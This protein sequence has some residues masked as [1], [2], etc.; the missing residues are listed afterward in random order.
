MKIAMFSNDTFQELQLL[1]QEKQH[2]VLMTHEKLDGD[3]CGALWA[4]FYAL[5]KYHFSLEIYYPGDI[6]LHFQHIIK[7]FSLPV[8]KDICNISHPSMVIVCDANNESVIGPWFQLLKNT[9]PWFTLVVFDHHA[10]S[11]HGPFGDIIFCDVSFSSTCELVYFFL[12]QVFGKEVFDECIATLLLMGIYTDTYCFLNSNTRSR[13]FFVA[14]KLMEYKAKHSYIVETFFRN[15]SIQLIKYIGSVLSNLQESDD[16]KIVWSV[17]EYRAYCYV[18]S[19]YFSFSSLLNEY[20]L[21][22]KN[23]CIAFFLYE[24]APWMV[25]GTFRTQC[26]NIDL[27]QLCS[28]FGWGGHKKAAGFLLQG[29]IFDIEKMVL[30]ECRKFIVWK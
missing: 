4:L 19:L 17:F 2:I 3:A 23:I 13:V 21:W 22:A 30:E 29:N 6:P 18:E 9:Y 20:V 8:I 1:F 10:P 25:K 14:S 7:H 5:K 26:E 27:S 12:E 16:G 11:T 24:M 28:R 15:K